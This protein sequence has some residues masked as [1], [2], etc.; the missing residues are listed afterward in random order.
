MLRAESK[1]ICITHNGKKKL[2]KIYAV[3]SE[4]GCSKNN[5]N[6][7]T[8]KKKRAGTTRSPEMA[9]CKV[10]CHGAYVTSALMSRVLSENLSEPIS[11]IRPHPKGIPL[12]TKIKRKT[13]EPEEAQASQLKK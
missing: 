7:T 2:K 3:M 13:N 8:K 5:N 10:K 1:L 11:Q 4:K 9:T 6:K 12:S